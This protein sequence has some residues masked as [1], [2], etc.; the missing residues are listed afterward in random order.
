MILAAFVCL[1]LTVPP[2]PA[3]RFTISGTVVSAA[4]G[5]PL[6]GARLSLTGTEGERETKTAT[7]GR[8]AFHALPAGRYNLSA[9]RAGFESSLFQQHDNFYTTL[10]LGP[11]LAATGLHLALAPEASLHGTIRDADG[12]PVGYAHV[13]LFRLNRK[14]HQTPQVQQAS[15]ND[16]GE[17]DFAP[18]Q[19]GEYFVAVTAMPWYSTPSWPPPPPPP[20]PPRSLSG[21]RIFAFSGMIQQPLLRSHLDVLY[22]VTYY[23]DVTESAAA[24]P[25]ILS[26]G[27][28]ARA[29]IT[30]TAVPALHLTMHFAESAP[31]QYQPSPQLLPNAFGHPLY[32]GN[33]ARVVTRADPR[34]GQIMYVSLP[35]GNY[36]VQ[37][38]NAPP[39]SLSVHSDLDMGPSL[40]PPPAL[41]NVTGTLRAAAK[42]PPLTGIP[43]FLRKAN[44]S[45]TANTDA[46]GRFQFPNVAAGEYELSTDYGPVRT[47][48]VNG[49]PVRINAVVQPRPVVASVYGRVV[50]AGHGAGGVL[51]VLAPANSA[52][53]D[54]ARMDQTDSDGTFVLHFVFTGRYRLIA[55]PAGWNLLATPRAF[56][57]RYGAHA[58]PVT[59]PGGGRQLTLAPVTV[60]P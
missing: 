14:S 16:A 19:P 12:D 48:A 30:L 4:S 43:V 2:P 56:L 52:S 39:L 36:D 59:I 32:G 28:Q 46:A 42:G 21:S 22:P 41:A 24:Q 58:L 34:G 6:P 18:L 35:P 44:L 29:D 38:Q 7:D 54:A 47:V 25:I 27:G 49:Q 13:A 60:Q 45:W 11:G 51:V 17:Y 3:P 23:G 10:V 53:W 37:R 57:R 40:P 26:A 8:F 9:S 33:I 20:P 50:R 15:A 31:G 1:Q 55:V 5:A